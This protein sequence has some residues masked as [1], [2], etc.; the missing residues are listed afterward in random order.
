MVFSLDVSPPTNL[1]ATIW[2][3][4]REDLQRQD[5]WL[6][7]TISHPPTSAPYYTT[8][9]AP[10]HRDMTNAFVTTPPRRGGPPPLS[11]LIADPSQLSGLSIGSASVPYQSATT[12]ASKLGYFVAEERGSL[13]RV[14]NKTAQ[15]GEIATNSGTR[16]EGTGF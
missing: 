12:V 8:P 1:A 16:E 15:T 5:G 13:E 9:L 2:A 11:K 10:L 3:I 6:D 14:Q 4:V 7:D